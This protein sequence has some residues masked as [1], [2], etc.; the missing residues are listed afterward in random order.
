MGRN[1]LLLELDGETVVR[2]AARRAMD[3]GMRPVVVVTGHEREAV[4]AELHGIG[5]RSVFNAEHA[6]GQHTSV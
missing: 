3:A 5:C 6:G 1:K 2:R 4:E